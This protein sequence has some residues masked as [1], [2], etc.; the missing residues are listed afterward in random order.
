VDAPHL[1]YTRPRTRFVASFIGRTNLI[2]ARVSGE[3]IGFAGLALQAMQIAGPPRQKEGEILLSVRPQ[4]MSLSTAQPEALNGRAALPGAVTRR[5]F[6]GETWDYVVRPD[7][8]DLELRVSAPPSQVH[9]VGSAV[10]LHLDP[11]EIV[12]VE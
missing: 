12:A 7:G 1:L 4:S 10:W 5:V 11:Q 2:P 6:L 9:E 3:E 8:G